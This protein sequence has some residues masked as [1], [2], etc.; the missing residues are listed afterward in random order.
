[1][2]CKDSSAED[3]CLTC[4]ENLNYIRENNNET[5]KCVAKPGYVANPDPTKPAD[6]CHFSC[7]T[8]SGTD[9]SECTGDC[10]EGRT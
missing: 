8:C 9:K 3:N 6:K 1:M 10:P 5:S 7:L 4:R 2:T